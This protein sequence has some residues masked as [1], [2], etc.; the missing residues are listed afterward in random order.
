[1]ANRDD[2]IRQML[3]MG[4]PDF[5][6]GHP[7][8]DGKIWRYGPKKKACYKLYE[9]RLRNGQYVVG[10]WFRIW[11]DLDVTKI[12]IDWKGITDEERERHARERQVTE[13]RE[14]N[15][16]AE[17]AADAA[18]RGRKQWDSG[19]TAKPENIETYLD[20]K[21]VAHTKGLR[22]FAD[23]TV[24]VPMIRYDIT[25]AQEQA[26]GY[27]G[28]RRLLGLQKISP[29]GKKL[30]NKGLAKEGAA[31]RL[32]GAPKMGE[33]IGLTE[34]LATGLSLRMGVD[35]QLAV[36]VAFDAGNLIHVARILRK[37]YPNNPILI[38]AD[39]DAYLTASMNK[40][41]RENYGLEETV[42]VPMTDW[43]FKGSVLQDGKRVPVE[44]V[45]SC[46]GVIDSDGVAGIVG[47]VR[48]G[49]RLYTF[50]RENA[51]RKYALRAAH[52]IG[53]AE[54][55]YPAFSDRKLHADPEGAKLTD[56][57]D[58]HQA[59]GLD[60]IRKQLV[61]D[62]DRI[63]VT[64]QVRSFVVAEMGKVRKAAR[65]GGGN[66]DKQPPRKPGEGFDWDRFFNRYTLIYP[67]DTLWDAQLRE[68][69]KLNAVKI[70]FT[71]PIVNWWLSD[72][73][74][75]MV[76]LD[77]LVFEPGQEVK[78]PAIN[79]FRGMPLK[80]STKGSCVKL[81][82]LLQYLCGEQGRDQ[83]PVTDWVFK[84]LAYPLQHVG[85]KMQTAIVMHGAEGTG[86][87]LFFGAVREIYGEYG[88]LITQTELED[89]FNGW[90]S[91]RLFV[92]ANEVISRAELRHHVGRLKNMVTEPVLPI[93]EMWSPI[94]YES[95][96]AQ[97]VFL[98]N[99]LQA[100]F[101]APGDRRYMVIRTPAAASPRFYSDVADEIAE[102]GIEAFYAYLL[103]Y[104]LGDFAEHTKPI[105]T[106]A[107]ED[108]IEM[109]LSSVQFFQQQLHEGLLHPLT[110]A[111]C[112][113][114]DLY[115]AYTA[116]CAR[117]GERNPAR[118][119]RFSHEFMAMNGVSRRVMDIDDAIATAPGVKRRQGTVMFMNAI[120]AAVVPAEIV[121]DTAW[122]AQ[123]KQSVAMWK[124]LLKEYLQ[125]D[126]LGRPSESGRQ[127]S[128]KDG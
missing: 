127:R 63:K 62:L 111:S 85:A 52:E 42:S 126:D 68:I 83:A 105:A 108:L 116:F 73:D 72:K 31:C 59:E 40:L 18:S 28:P 75:R 115:R 29:D 32:G 77:Q 122:R 82:E 81:R 17:R 102:G 46:E 98:T 36:F 15:K 44:L 92:I 125:Q 103:E 48:H 23:G 74:R 117:T 12:Q 16:E 101:L 118:L 120:T 104:P 39:D 64:A 21:G 37:L 47:A 53:N 19:R 26:T 121:D 91:R 100:L 71:E 110:Y 3:A 107:K 9:F 2:A 106:A 6:P 95:N 97:L 60:V 96:H 54:V 112:L 90:L 11:G 57:N 99:E 123:V 65:S 35:E 30:F 79:L 109:G 76:N 58:L 38:F 86:K 22:Y 84:W 66:G 124:G 41:L 33:P 128:L 7:I 4:M 89:R 27:T 88:T 45:V 43:K 34:G 14:R 56:F 50:T 119:N 113:S 69:V 61:P 5:P 25:E 13:A 8:V 49:E 93:R 20:R 70:A 1:M 24:L 94:R 10:G 87:N 78:P 55:I 67:T 51:G 114:T 80:A